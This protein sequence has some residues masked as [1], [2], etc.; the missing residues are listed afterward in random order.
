MTLQDIITAIVGHPAEC[1]T[2][3]IV[4][5]LVTVKKLELP[6]WHWLLE[7]LLKK[8]DALGQ[9]IN[10]SLNAEVAGLRGDVKSLREQLN[11]HILDADKREADGWRASILHFNVE[12]IQHVPHTREDFIEILT[13]IDAYE[14]YC[15]THPDYENNRAV[16]AVANI[17]R[18]YAERLQKGFKEDT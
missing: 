3:A 8:A 15:E 6:V 9:C 1:A 14:T 5:G 16:L 12:L 18:V 2:G 17:K 4:L 7:W 11:T 10:A 13:D